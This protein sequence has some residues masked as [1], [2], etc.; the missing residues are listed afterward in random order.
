MN[1]EN[2]NKSIWGDQQTLLFTQLLP[3][4]ILDIADSHGFKT[5]GRVL[6][7][8][9]MENRVYEMEVEQGSI[10]AKFYRPGRWGLETLQDE[11][12]F[13]FDLKEQ[14][15]PIVAPSQIDGESL[16]FNEELSLYYCFYERFGGRIDSELT[17]DK[18]ESIGRTIA[19]M[20]NIGEMKPAKNR[21]RLD[22]DTF[23]HANK[24]FLLEFKSNDSVFLGQFNYFCDEFE[25]TIVDD[26]F[27]NAKY[28]RA[29]GDL[30]F[31]NIIWRDTSHYLIDFD[32]MLMAPSIQDLFF[33]HQNIETTWP[34]LRDSFIDSYEL[35]REYP[36]HEEK[37]IPLLRILRQLNYQVW[38]S[39][40]HEDL[41]FQRGFPQ[42]NQGNFWEI[43][44]GDLRLALMEWQQK[45]ISNY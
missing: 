10:V 6:T 9:S 2:K 34:D 24:A 20:H 15:I 27:K 21:S 13:M 18:V 28:L 29:H 44:V 31:G 25:K 11:H 23:Y 38:I 16:F 7:L 33:I 43:F 26:P 3:E 8:N 37:L 19:R 41:A 12:D 32:D 30:H 45:S 17:K 14:E 35:F 5:T 1:E 40:R 39:K 22:L 42:F 4:V 36:F